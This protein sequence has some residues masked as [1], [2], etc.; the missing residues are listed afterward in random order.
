VL[1]VFHAGVVAA[2]RERDRQLARLGVDVCLV[3]AAR[4][5]EGGTPVHF[6]ADGDSFARAARAFGRHP[7]RFLF[8]PRPIWRLL[9]T[10][11]FDLLDLQEE[12]C[13]LATAEVLVLRWLARRSELP[14]VLYSAQNISKRY[15]VPFR[16]LERAALRHASGVS[17]CN[18][19]AGEILRSKG[20]SAPVALLPLGFDPDH[21]RTE[22]RAAPAPDKFRVGY[23]GRLE[24]HKGVAVLLQAIASTERLELLIAGSGPEER[25]LHSL[26]EQLCL[27]VRARFLGFLSQ[28]ELAP[29]YRSLD[30]LAVPSL[31][32]AGWR[33]QFGR[34]AVE[35]MACGVP[36]VASR[37]GALPEVVGDGGLLVPPGDPEALRVALVQLANDPEHWLQLRHAGLERV[38]PWFRAASS[39]EFGFAG[40]LC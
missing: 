12:P 11:R 2:W 29:F 34:V 38:G 1:H 40:L 39:A 23:V 26:A 25:S 36:I 14:Y 27:G 24:A 18:D 9:R 31:P 21:L 7:N 17:V 15:P 19:A 10:R 20:L 3:S 5:I 8:D 22:P 33:E 16:W 37:S 32:R 13:A 6:S 30:C 35:A 4:F 28:D